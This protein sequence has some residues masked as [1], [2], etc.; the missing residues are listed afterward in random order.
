MKYKIWRKENNKWDLAFDCS[1]TKEKV[2]ERISELNAVHNNLVKFGKL[3]FR[4]FSEDVKNP[5]NVLY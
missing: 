2:E 4:Y 5:N 1:F 3:Q